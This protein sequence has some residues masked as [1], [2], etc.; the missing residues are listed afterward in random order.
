M[1]FKIDSGSL[2]WN[3][4]D[5]MRKKPWIIEKQ[6]RRICFGF[7]GYIDEWI[8]YSSHDTEE[9]AKE[10]LKKLQNFA[11]P[12]AHERYQI[13]DNRNVTWTWK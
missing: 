4:Y 8:H 11:D 6:V 7:P 3:D 1:A 5:L 13:T 9:Y 2:G 10:E 12:L